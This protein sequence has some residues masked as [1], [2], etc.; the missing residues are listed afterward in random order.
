MLLDLL[1]EY[2]RA[3][4]AIFGFIVVPAFLLWLISRPF[5]RLLRE[6]ETAVE[7]TE[8]NSK[9]LK[10]LV[11]RM[12]FTYDNWFDHLYGPTTNPYD[13]KWTPAPPP[14]TPAPPPT[15]EGIVSSFKGQPGGQ[16]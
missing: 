12:G 13:P 16:L 9:L 5:A 7:Q 10:V 15:V 3:M 8:R 14:W 2:T 4:G 1:R 6:H 11:A